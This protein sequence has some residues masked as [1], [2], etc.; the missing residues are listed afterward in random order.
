MSKYQEQSKDS[1][2]SLR[3]EVYVGSTQGISRPMWILNDKT[4]SLEDIKLAPALLRIL[5]EILCNA[6]D[7]A[8]ESKK[9]GIV[10]GIVTL[11]LEGDT[12]IVTNGGKPMPIE[13]MKRADGAEDWIPSVM[14]GRMFSSSHYNDGEERTTAG[15]NGIGAKA[16]NALSVLFRVRVRDGS[17]SFEQ[18]WTKEVG[19]KASTSK[20]IIRDCTDSPQVEVSF[21]PDMSRF[22]ETD[23]LQDHPEVLRKLCS[24]LALC[25]SVPIHYIQGETTIVYDY[26]RDVK[27]AMVMRDSLKYLS[28]TSGGHRIYLLT[29]AYKPVQ[30]SYVNGTP[31]YRHGSHVNA[32]FKALKLQLKTVKGL[33]KLK[34]P[35]MANVISFVLCSTVD[36]PRFD[37]NNKD[38]LINPVKDLTLPSTLLV[39][40]KKSIPN[41]TERLLEEMNRNAR[42]AANKRT[43]G[44][45]RGDHLR[46][47]TFA[48]RKTSQKKSLWI[49]EGPSAQ[50]YVMDVIMAL[51]GNFDHDGV[52][53]IRGK[54]LKVRS[55][56]IDMITGENG[57]EEVKSVLRTLGLKIG[58]DYSKQ[59]VRDKLRY[60]RLVIGSDAD[61]DGYHIRALLTDMIEQFAPALLKTDFLYIMNSPIVRLNIRDKRLI[62]Y[63]E[64]EWDEWQAA[65]TKGWSRANVTYCK[66]LGS[67]S[68]QLTRRDARE[69]ADR[70]LSK[71]E[72]DDKS[73]SALQMAFDPKATSL[74][75]EWILGTRTIDTT[76]YM[77]S[78]ANLIQLDLRKY[79][80][81]SLERAI[82]GWDGFNKSQRMLWWTMTHH[83]GIKKCDE[84]LGDVLKTVEYKHGP[85]SLYGALC[86]MTA[87]YPGTNNLPICIP[88]GRMGSRK[89]LG[90][91]AAASR[92]PASGLRS[93]VPLLFRPD[94]VPLL[95]RRVEYGDENE[96]VVAHPVLP[97]YLINHCTGI[98]TGWSTFIPPHNPADVA[99]H[100]RI[101]LLRRLAPEEELPP[102]T[103]LVPWFRYY[104]GTVELK[105]ASDNTRVSDENGYAW[106]VKEGDTVM[107]LKGK[108][109]TVTKPNGRVVSISEIPPY[110]S[111]DSFSNDAELYCDEKKY[112]ILSN[113]CLRS[114]DFSFLMPTAHKMDPS[115]CK[116]LGLV[117]RRTLSN[118]YILGEDG[119]P[120]HIKNA[121][122]G[123]RMYV[124]WNMP[125]Y[126]R[127]HAHLVSQLT[128]KIDTESEY[129]RFLTDVVAGVF[130]PRPRRDVT[131]AAEYRQQLI[132]SGYHVSVADRYVIWHNQ[133]MIDTLSKTIAD[134]TIQKEKLLAKKPEELWL[135][136]L[137]EL[138]EYLAE[139]EGDEEAIDMPEDESDSKPKSKTVRRKK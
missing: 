85:T 73:S 65:H 70:I 42:I 100:L 4:Q 3:P 21:I 134:L 99:H 15:L 131:S 97:M 128:N 116:A 78:I 36:R 61:D 114:V 60:D 53:A 62:F 102:L 113:N 127:R 129:K 96:P 106:D 56:G 63:T 101:H 84:I 87:G 43:K 13:K 117:T 88:E 79:A 38:Q 130:D 52:L 136:D 17:K 107:L 75:K 54:P 29:P 49:A 1:H 109:S 119:V 47:A 95:T 8:D 125:H 27:A 77:M 31:T 76:A 135:D 5:I 110:K 89:E 33:E 83:N 10:P 39:D 59:E 37:G 123:V 30:E 46:D 132:S 11:R 41:L 23:R 139:H 91:D 121:D 48:G 55:K 138:F 81:Q 80:I 35:A 7:N 12:L 32:L 6:S 90:G 111:T 98:A 64:A 34:K 86:G 20:P 72:A 108:Y 126:E 18:V 74:R 112:E 137:D 44:K 57:N 24:D 104:K 50:T 120:I 93:H 26:S 122:E 67:S 25:S 69:G 14:F 28:Y 115:R 16:C 118:M 9:E 45:L 2:V 105:T 66:G 94:D 92:Y 58:E 124:D 68:P 103:P 133:T 40:L 82:P 51:K 19:S 71:V 22:D